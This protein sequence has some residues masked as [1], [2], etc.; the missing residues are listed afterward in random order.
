M[1]P[2]SA[3]SS[4]LGEDDLTV[5]F[6]DDLC[7]VLDTG[8]ALALYDGA[9][10]FPLFVFGILRIYVCGMPSSKWVCQTVCQKPKI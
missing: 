3:G 1:L 2:A 8:F 6:F 10:Y 5:V 7:P 9:H 4:S